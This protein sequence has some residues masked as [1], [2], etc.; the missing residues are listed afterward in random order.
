M[1]DQRDAV[2]RRVAGIVQHRDKQVFAGTIAGQADVVF[3]NRVA[4]IQKVEPGLDRP[5]REIAKVVDDVMAI[6]RTENI[7]VTTGATTHIVIAGAAEQH[8]TRPGSIVGVDLTGIGAFEIHNRK[9]HAEPVPDDTIGKDDFFDTGVQARAI[10]KK[11]VQFAQKLIL[12]A[13]K[14]PF[15]VIVQ[16]HILSVADRADVI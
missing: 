5:E 12:Q 16:D 13:N 1:S 4:E 10:L 14:I 9:G 3:G 15:R 7:G 8:I 6:A 2:T 11:G